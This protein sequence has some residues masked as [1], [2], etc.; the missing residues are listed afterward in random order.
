MRID[1]EKMRSKNV[2]RAI[3]ARK[4]SMADIISRLNAIAENPLRRD[5]AEVLKRAYTAAVVAYFDE[6][7]NS[8]DGHR[9]EGATPV[10]PT[11]SGNR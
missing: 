4:H 7:K 11:V 1:M 6:R 10:A 9:F 5:E 2:R 3:S 8:R